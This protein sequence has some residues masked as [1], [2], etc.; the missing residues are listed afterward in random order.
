MRDVSLM[1]DS[2]PAKAAVH[3][4]ASNDIEP[5]ERAIRGSEGNGLLPA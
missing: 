5:I 3:R 2:L 4:A 1:I